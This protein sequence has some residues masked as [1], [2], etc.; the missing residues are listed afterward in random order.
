MTRVGS[1]GEG[2]VVEL[3]YGWGRKVNGL[4]VGLD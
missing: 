4:P 2:G 3:P 1:E